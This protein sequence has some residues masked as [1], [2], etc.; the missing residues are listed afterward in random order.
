M[1]TS[2]EWHIMIYNNKNN[3]WVIFYEPVSLSEESGRVECYM[4]NLA[5]GDHI[6][7]I[8]LP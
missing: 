3:H 8:N 7:S 2:L 5:C 4:S 6:N 1:I